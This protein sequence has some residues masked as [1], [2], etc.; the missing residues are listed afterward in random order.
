MQIWYLANVSCYL[1]VKTIRGC[2]LL[3]GRTNIIPQCPTSGLHELSSPVAKCNLQWIWLLLLTGI[4]SGRFTNTLMIP[5]LLDLLIRKNTLIKH[6]HGWLWIENKFYKTSETCHLHKI[7][8]SPMVWGVTLIYPLQGE[9]KL[10]HLFHPTA[11][12]EGQ[13]LVNL[14]WIFDATYTSF[15]RATLTLLPSNWKTDSFD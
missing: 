8:K 9:G 10:L 6:M 14:L 12:K 15:G 3:L 13:C 4:R 2:L 11:K 7:S 5:C 1:L